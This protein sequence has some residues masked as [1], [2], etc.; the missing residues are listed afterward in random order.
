MCAPDLCAPCTSPSLSLSTLNGY[1]NGQTSHDSHTTTTAAAADTAL[2]P[3]TICLLLAHSPANAPPIFPRFS[4]Q[5]P[6]THT[7]ARAHPQHH[8]PNL[9]HPKQKNQQASNQETSS[10]D[11]PKKRRKSPQIA[12]EVSNSMSL[13]SSLRRQKNR[14][15][16]KRAKPQVFVWRKSGRQKTNKRR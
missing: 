8:H 3:T 2:Q 6:A 7:R 14:R 10:R 13:E 4:L 11:Y 15:Q 1:Y 12:D 16:K 5:Q 9:L